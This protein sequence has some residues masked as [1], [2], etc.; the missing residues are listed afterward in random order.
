MLPLSAMNSKSIGLVAAKDIK[1]QA[2]AQTLVDR[3]GFTKL[4]PNADN[5]AVDCDKLV[6]VGGDGFMLH[7][8]HNVIECG[9][10]VYGVHCGTVGFLMN[11]YDEDADLPAR[12]DAAQVT[13]VRPLKM[14]AQ[15]TEG[16]TEERLAI[17]EVSLSRATAQAAKISISV[18]GTLQMKEMI[19][20]GVLVSTPA[21]SSAY[22]FSCGGPIVP[23]GSELLSVTPISPFR[24]RRWRGALLPSNITVSMQVHDSEKRPV[25]AVADFHEVTN[26]SQVDVSIDDKHTINLL[27]DEGHSLEDRIIKEQFP[28]SPPL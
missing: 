16:N 23:I 10:P 24:P 19:A 2:V 17:N 13:D 18:D 27:F 20:D 25:T 7:T 26:V 14:V 12:I 5:C 4:D 1:A 22:N 8:L 28:F 21:G 3:Y 15:T 9:T 11:G 6:A